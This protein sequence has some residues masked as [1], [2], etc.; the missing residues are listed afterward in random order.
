[1]PRPAEPQFS[2]EE[3]ALFEKGVALYN[4]GY[5]FECHDVLEELWSGVRG[6]ARDFLQG[7]IQIAVGHYHLGNAN[8]EGAASMFA[9]ALKRLDGYPDGYFGF[10]LAAQRQ[11]LRTRLARLREAGCDVPAPAARPR[12]SFAGSS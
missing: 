3:G 5:Y 1:M 8:R 10:A 12:W 6:P 11:E 4:D 9:R 2:S 7:L